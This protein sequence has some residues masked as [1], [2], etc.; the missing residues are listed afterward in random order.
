LGVTTSGLSGAGV[1]LVRLWLRYRAKKGHERPEKISPDNHKIFTSDEFFNFI[2]EKGIAH[3]TRA[4]YEHE[5]GAHVERG[6]QTA[7]NM[8]RALL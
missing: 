2:E 5:Q 6:I 4:S 7:L 8:V 3:E 1:L